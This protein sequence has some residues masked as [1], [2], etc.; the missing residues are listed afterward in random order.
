MQVAREFG[1]EVFVSRGIMVPLE[2]CYR[3]NEKLTHRTIVRVER[4]YVLQQC[5]NSVNV[6]RI[7]IDY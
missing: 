7:T 4:A 1:R 2:A 5:N 3:A 6:H